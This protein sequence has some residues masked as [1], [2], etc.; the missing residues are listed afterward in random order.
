MVRSNR[1]TTE[2]YYKNIYYIALQ[3]YTLSED[4]LLSQSIR[5]GRGAISAMQYSTQVPSRSLS[6]I[7]NRD[8]LH[9]SSNIH[10][11][12][13][14]LIESI[15]LIWQRC[16]FSYTIF[17]TTMQ[18]LIHVPSRS[19]NSTYNR[20][21]LHS[22]SNIHVLRGLLIESINSI[23]RRCHSAMQYP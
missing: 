11:L 8:L 14:L 21:L 23:W 3:I 12:R 6:S 17:N 15:N 18:Y 20:D 4:H 7:Y 16:H 10:A 13:G 19:L 1:P 2:N 22:P 5:S 9:R